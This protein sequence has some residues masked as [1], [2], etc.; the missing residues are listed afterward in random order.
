MPSHPYVAVL[1]DG[2]YWGPVAISYNSVLCSINPTTNPE[3]SSLPSGTVIVADDAAGTM[4]QYLRDKLPHLSRAEKIALRARRG[5]SPCVCWYA[6]QS[7]GA[8]E[9]FPNEHEAAHNILSGVQ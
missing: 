7:I 5:W 3:A 1:P 8:M 9:S 2:R 4:D 6:G